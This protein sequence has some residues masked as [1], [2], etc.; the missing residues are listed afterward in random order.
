M[1]LLLLP[2]RPS[3]PVVLTTGAL[4]ASFAMHGVE[5]PMR[6]V[7]IS[8]VALIAGSAASPVMAGP[9]W[10]FQEIQRPLHAERPV[11]EG[12]PLTLRS[13]LDEALA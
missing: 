13:T 4:C 2:A 11:Y 8:V 1:C 7:L 5:R 3:F 12:P 6:S 10:S 9:I